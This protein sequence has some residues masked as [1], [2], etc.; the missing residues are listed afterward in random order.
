[1]P[2]T[3]T[4]NSKLSLRPSQIRKLFDLSNYLADLTEELLEE[5]AQYSKKFIKGL[6]KSEKDVKEG[7]VKEIKSLRELL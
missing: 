3:S 1:M 7:R 2:Q 5:S 6:K 4:K